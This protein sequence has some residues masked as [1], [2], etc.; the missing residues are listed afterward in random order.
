MEPA[1]V[2]SHLGS[3]TGP[4]PITEDKRLTLLTTSYREVLDATKHQDDKVG[5]LLTATAF[6][7]AAA[8][9]LANLVGGRALPRPFIIGRESLPPLALLALLVFLLCVVLA[10]VMLVYS[11]A[12][13]LKIPA[14]VNASREGADR[15]FSQ[16]YF[17]SIAELA[18]EEWQAKWAVDQTPKL[19]GEAVS[20][21]HLRAH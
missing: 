4:A 18:K 16:I 10:A 13:P 3:T 15:G 8:L 21:T 20:Y 2:S 9:A 17:F 5:R 1:E 19:E 11:I 6:L 14:F 7:T 12:T